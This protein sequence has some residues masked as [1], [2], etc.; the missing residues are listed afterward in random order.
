MR[1]WDKI[2]WRKRIEN[3]SRVWDVSTLLGFIPCQHLHKSKTAVRSKDSRVISDSF[4]KGCRWAGCKRR[5]TWSRLK[6][7]SLWMGLWACLTISETLLK[8]SV[9]ALDMKYCQNCSSDHLTKATTWKLPTRNFNHF[10]SQIQMYE[11]VMKNATPEK[12]ELR[13]P[14][15]GPNRWFNLWKA[16]V[17]EVARGDKH[18][19][20]KTADRNVQN[21]QCYPQDCVIWGLRSADFLK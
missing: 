9:D 1:L 16:I 13:S 15:A 14:E 11:C 5:S 19:L 2:P 17:R 4:R 21:K 10:E 3:P 8:P 20:R 6:F 12:C 18:N 7:T